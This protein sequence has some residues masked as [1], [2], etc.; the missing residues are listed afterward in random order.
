MASNQAHN[1]LLGQ[2]TNSA[3]ALDRALGTIKSEWRRFELER[4]EWDIE[5]VRLKVQLR[6]SEKRI[7]LLTSQYQASQRQ[8]NILESILSEN[9]RKSDERPLSMALS[10]LSASNNGG[11]NGGVSGSG[12]AGTVSDLVDA[13]ATNRDRSKDLLRRCLGEI[14]IL[15]GKPS[16][17]FPADVLASAATFAKSAVQGGSADINVPSSIIE[18]EITNPAPLWQMP[19]LVS[20]ASSVAAVALGRNVR[21]QLA[22]STVAGKRRRTSKV[23][24]QDQ[25]ET[26]IAAVAAK[27]AEDSGRIGASSSAYSDSGADTQLVGADNSPAP[28]S[29]LIAQPEQSEQPFKPDNFNV[30]KA[31]TDA[32]T[33]SNETRR[34]HDD[35]SE[36]VDCMV[37]IKISDEEEHVVDNATHNA[38]VQRLTVDEID[39]GDSTVKRVD[40]SDWQMHKTFVGHLDTVRSISVRAD[41]SSNG[42]DGGPLPQ[43]LSGSDDGLVILWDIERSSRRKSRRRQAHDVLPGHIYRGHLA[44]VTSVV[45]AGSHGFAYSGSLDSSIKVWQL[46]DDLHKSEG[47]D[48]EASFPAGQCCLGPGA[49]D[50]RW[51]AGV[52]VG[53]RHM[54]GLEHRPEALWRAAAQVA[55]GAVADIRDNRADIDVLCHGGRHQVGCGL[56]ER[57]N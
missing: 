18:S 34:A 32:A 5:R 31:A 50:D 16:S 47:G 12:S 55:S 10:E 25:S 1:P 22:E 33:G 28:S 3:V 44:A 20:T 36:M 2:A 41:H 15:L 19:A 43:L 17:A 9:K 54:Q 40:S 35:T 51:A 23:L 6:A 7:D 37:N 52:G 27:P 56:H 24:L 38:M 53:R 29:P 13:S 48:P 42:P 30:D 26:V 11:A 14:D 4:A 45:F 21:P 57:P 49:V 8:L 46:P 39:I